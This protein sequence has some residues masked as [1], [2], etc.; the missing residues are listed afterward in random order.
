MQDEKLPPSSTGTVHELSFDATTAPMTAELSF[1]HI[2]LRQFW[3][4]NWPFLVPFV[5]LT[6]LS[7]ILG[8][9]LTGW[10]GVGVGEVLAV[11][12]LV[13]GFYAVTRR[14][15]ETRRFIQKNKV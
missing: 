2:S 4:R 3:V 8:L 12:N 10:I 5:L 7:P 14:V 13:I 11:M 9:W 6:F 15:T 1:E